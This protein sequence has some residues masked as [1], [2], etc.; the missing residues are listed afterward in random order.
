MNKQQ[1][2]YEQ[3][4]KTALATMNTK[5]SFGTDAMDSLP[6]ENKKQYAQN[7]TDFSKEYMDIAHQ[8]AADVSKLYDLLKSNKELV[9]ALISFTSITNIDEDLQH[10]YD[11]T[12]KANHTLDVFF[13]DIQ[14]VASKLGLA[15]AYQERAGDGG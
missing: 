8:I 2:A 7:A 13:G 10:I 15:A 9:D 6:L 3:G 1:W 4:W 5:S 14:S 11:D 12:N